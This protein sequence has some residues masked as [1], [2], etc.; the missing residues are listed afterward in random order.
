MSAASEN[1]EL[2]ELLDRLTR[3]ANMMV[4]FDNDNTEE[5]DRL[6]NRIIMLTT[7]IYGKNSKDN[8]EG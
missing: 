8:K 3:K 7:I 6:M 1:T 2:K 4:L 5:F